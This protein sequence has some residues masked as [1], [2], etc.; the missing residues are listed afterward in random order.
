M[1]EFRIA[2]QYH[3]SLVPHSDGDSSLPFIV[4]PCHLVWAIPPKELCANLSH[5]SFESNMAHV[6]LEDRNLEL[7]MNVEFQCDLM[8]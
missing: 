3:E 2:R 6:L 5:N 7:E 4:N 8:H 1:S